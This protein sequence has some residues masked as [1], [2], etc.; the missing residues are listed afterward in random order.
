MD[1]KEV[2]VKQ[3]DGD[4]EEA[5]EQEEQVEPKINEQEADRIAEKRTERAERSAVTSYFKQQGLSDE[6]AKEAFEDYKNKKAVMREEEMNS[7]N[8]LRTKVEQY[9]NAET[10][11][12]K[13]ANRRLV[14]A[15]AK[16]MAV[17]LKIKPERVDHAIRLADLSGVDVDE[18]GNVDEKALR[19]ALEK[20][21]EEIPE[22]LQAS[23]S[24]EESKPGF[25]LGGSGGSGTAK[26]DALAK[27][28]GN[29]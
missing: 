18:N 23:E 10:E 9:E 21:A 25:K 16:V 11:A 1:I 3:V 8:A 22:L 13:V 19:E 6:E 17:T 28:F 12:M 5:G 4:Q 24:A 27:I 26:G 2:D 14:R 7:I 20:V 15:D 29:K